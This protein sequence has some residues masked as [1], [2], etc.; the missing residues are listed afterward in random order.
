MISSIIAPYFATAIVAILGIVAY[1]FKH[2]T[3][4]TQIA[5]VQADAAQRVMNATQ[6]RDAAL[7]AVAEVRDSM[8]QTNS[9][10]AQKGLDAAQ[11]RANAEEET[12]TASRGD[13]LKFMQEHGFVR[14]E[15]GG[16]VA[17]TGVGTGTSA[18]HP[19]TGTTTGSQG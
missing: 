8:A 1:L 16:S 12:R 17:S 19:A 14:N 6:E 9:A 4:K 11:E 10:V 2:Q 18:D 15:G 5:T 7:T 13:N 3:T